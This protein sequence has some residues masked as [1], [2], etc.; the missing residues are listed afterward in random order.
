MKEQKDAFWFKHDINARNDSKML[1]IRKKYSNEG[2]AIFFFIVEMLREEEDY[3]LKCDEIFISALTY[4]IDK[5]NEETK[6]FI[7]DCIKCGLLETDGEYIWSNSLSRRMKPLDDLRKSQSEGGKKSSKNKKDNNSL[8]SNSQDT[9]KILTT[10]LQQEEEKR[11]EEKIEEIKEE[12]KKDIASS[13]KKKNKSTPYDEIQK[14]Y[15]QECP[16]LVRCQVMNSQRKRLFKK[17]W[18]TEPSLPFWEGLFRKANSIPFLQGENDRGWK[19]DFESLMTEKIMTRTLE[20]FYDNKASPKN[21]KSVMEKALYEF[22]KDEG[23]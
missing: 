14:L 10:D 20:G 17:R 18:E 5:E 1:Y 16:N 22:G 23:G 6:E 9:S 11:R 8:S 21:G 7:D 2:Y 15:N 4:E 19:A 13:Q 12:P 3:R